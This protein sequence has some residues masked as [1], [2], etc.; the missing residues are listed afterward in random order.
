VPYF[1]VDNIHS[2]TCGCLQKMLVYLAIK[3]LIAIQGHT[4]SLI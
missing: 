3:R 2:D 4:R 1:S